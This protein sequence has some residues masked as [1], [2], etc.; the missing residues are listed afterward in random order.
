MDNTREDSLY[1]LIKREQVFVKTRKQHRWKVIQ[2]WLT[3]IFPKKF[4]DK[5]CLK[6][7]TFGSPI[8]EVNLEKIFTNTAKAGKFGAAALLLCQIKIL[9]GHIYG[10]IHRA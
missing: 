5:K 9:Y 8:N 4:C 2:G 6:K 1:N 3:T 7:E 10:S